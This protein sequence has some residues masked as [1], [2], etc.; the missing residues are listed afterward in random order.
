MIRKEHFQHWVDSA[1][2][3]WEASQ[4][5]FT[6]GQNDWSLFL[7]HSV[8]EKLLRAIWTKGHHKGKPPRT[9]RLP[10]LARNLGLKFPKQTVT[11]FNTLDRF[12]EKTMYPDYQRSFQRKCT[13]HF[14]E[15]HLTKIQ[16]II[17]WLN[18]KL[19]S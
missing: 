16:E 11:Y 7:A 15:K 4:D 8:L 13:K 1:S 19:A 3:D 18:Q 17:K 14:A 10:W 5:L 12:A 2:L 6:R 9:D